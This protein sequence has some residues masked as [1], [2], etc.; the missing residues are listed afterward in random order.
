[1]VWKHQFR[2]LLSPGSQSM[3]NVTT[4]KIMLFRPTQI[5]WNLGE[6]RYRPEKCDG[7][8]D[9]GQTDRQ[10]DID[11][12]QSCLRQLKC[13]AKILQ[14]LCIIILY[15]YIYTPVLS[16]CARLNIVLFFPYVLESKYFFVWFLLLEC[17]V[18]LLFSLVKLLPLFSNGDESRESSILFELP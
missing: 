9:G 7:Q 15:M 2:L 3:A 5:I 10:T 14:T 6:R 12:L 1:M 16:N 18:S 17:F 8:M 4:I 11:F 13:I